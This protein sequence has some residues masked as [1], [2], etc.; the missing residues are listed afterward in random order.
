[1]TELESPITTA[2]SPASE[3]VQPPEAPST[4]STG[5]PP[6]SRLNAMIA[7]LAILAIALN[8]VLRFGFKLSPQT[9]NLPLY[10]AL[11]LGGTPLVYGLLRQLLRGK[12]G[13]DLLAGISIVTAVLLHEYLAGTLVVLML[14]GGEALEAYAVRSASSVLRALAK[15]MPSVAHA[16]RNGQVVEINAASIVPGDL[17]VV[18]PHEICPADGTVVEGHG[19]MDESYLTGEP[20]QIAKAPGSDVLSGAVNGPSLLVVEATRPPK[21]SR[22][23]KIMEVMRDSEQQRPQLRRLGDTLGALYTPL[24]VAIALV[25]GIVAHDPIRFLAVLVVATPCPL[26]IAIPVA[27]IGSISLAAKRGIIVKDPAVLEQ[28]STCR[29]IFFDKTGTLTYGEPRL[30]EIVV[31]PEFDENDVLQLAAT[32]EVYSKHPL[33]SAVQSAAEERSIPVLDVMDV[34]EPPGQGLVGTVNGRRITITGRKK[35]S[36]EIAAQLP[37]IAPGLECILLVDGRYAATFRFRDE[38]REDVKSFIHHL[39]PH[40]NIGRLILLTGDRK[41]EAEHLAKRVGI[42]TVYAEK[43]PEEKLAIVKAETAK[44]R[45]AYLGDGINDAPSLLAA[46]VGIAFGKTSDV[47]AEAASAVILDSSLRKVDEFI[48]ISKRLRTIALQSAV[49]GMAL[50]LIAIAFAATGHLPPV[51]GALTQ[52]A[53]DVLA[54]LNALRAAMRPRAISDM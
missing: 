18:R 22:Y 27:I 26:L 8:L 12:F 42:D 49:G 33:A 43:S 6:E 17:L 25:A 21:D 48:H 2:R 24:A 10:V 13:S 54:V 23:A 16:R 14:S 44:N 30:T 41:A 38:P 52:E 39:E 46:T 47:T 1:M 28:L 31:A 15:R 36:P 51:F 37:P 32:L 19:S 35:V 5:A 3:I 40:H 29:T 11:A 50:S 9:Y 20:Y 4:A 7:A 45:T 34:H 53:I